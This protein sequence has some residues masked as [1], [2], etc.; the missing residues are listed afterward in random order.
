MVYAALAISIYTKLPHNLQSNLRWG[1][2]L[3]HGTFAPGLLH[4]ISHAYD[5]KP[6]MHL[7]SLCMQEKMKEEFGKEQKK[8]MEEQEKMREEHEKEL[9][10]L[11]VL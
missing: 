5:I 3:N 8:M 1:M 2:L 11:K 9:Q 4:L 6:N 10:A 7:A